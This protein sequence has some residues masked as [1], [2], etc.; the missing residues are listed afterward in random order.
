MDSRAL[1]EEMRPPAEA[2][3]TLRCCNNYPLSR[4]HRITNGRHT[5]SQPSWLTSSTERVTRTEMPCPT[6][7]SDRIVSTECNSS[8]TDGDTNCPEQRK[9]IVAAMRHV[10]EEEEQLRLPHEVDGSADAYRVPRVPCTPRRTRMTRRCRR[11]YASEASDSLWLHQP[12]ESAVDS[13]QNATGT[14][15]PI[16]TVDVRGKHG[17]HNFRPRWISNRRTDDRVPPELDLFGS[18][19]SSR[20]TKLAGSDRAEEWRFQYEL[21]A[22]AAFAGRFFPVRYPDIKLTVT[23]TIRHKYATNCLC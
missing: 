12:V 23:R 14:T 3:A 4:N 18:E 7:T 11:G 20:G 19:C 5:A 9:K 16:P 13:S 8:A 10:E 6:A 17:R 15:G 22:N 1:P 2:T 21:F